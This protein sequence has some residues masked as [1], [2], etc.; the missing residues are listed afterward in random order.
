MFYSFKSVRNEVLIYRNNVHVATAR[1]FNA[2][3][4]WVTA[5]RQKHS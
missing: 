4:D 3:N 1:T 2:A 5:D